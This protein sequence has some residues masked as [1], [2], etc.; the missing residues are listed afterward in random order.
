MI[1]QV[2][3][4]GGG[5]KDRGGIKQANIKLRFNRN[6]VIGGASQHRGGLGVRAHSRE[7]GIGNGQGER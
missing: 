5:P 2:A 4:I 1:D 7:G 6:P 3:I